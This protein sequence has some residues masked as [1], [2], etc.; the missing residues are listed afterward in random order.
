MARQQPWPARIGRTLR[1]YATVLPF[2]GRRVAAGV[3]VLWA[4]S[5]AT[6]LLFFARPAILVARSMAGKEPTAAELRQ[7]TRQLGLNQPIAAQYWHYIDRLLH[8]N[9][10]Y[11]YV[12]GEPVTTILAQDLP[13]T[14]RWSPGGRGAS[15]R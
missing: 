15:C 7:I 5:L 12:T 14:R 1:G 9:L 11:S 3:V 6:F 2:L 8:G 4:V 10:G 13:R